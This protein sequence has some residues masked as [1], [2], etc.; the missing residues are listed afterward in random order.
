[1]RIDGGRGGLL[2]DGTVRS[3]RGRGGSLLLSLEPI[4]GDL[5]ISCG[6]LLNLVGQRMNLGK[7]CRVISE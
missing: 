2:V 5:K 3:D 1:M 4:L 7:V 6:L